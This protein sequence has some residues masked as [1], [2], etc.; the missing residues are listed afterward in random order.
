MNHFCSFIT[1]FVENIEMEVMLCVC[2][3]PIFLVLNYQNNQV[4]G[5]K[6]IKKLKQFSFQS[7]EAQ[8]PPLKYLKM[9]ISVI[10]K[11]FQLYLKKM[12]KRRTGFAFLSK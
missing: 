11:W 9:I 12:K 8:N 7:Y 1:F 5:K 4:N 3:R 2:E 10:L 6:I